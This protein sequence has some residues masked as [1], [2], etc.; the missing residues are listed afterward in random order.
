MNSENSP[1]GIALVFEPEPIVEGRGELPIIINY[2]I[3]SFALQFVSPR[4]G[5]SPYNACS[6]L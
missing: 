4:I 6:Y 1:E 2:E 3:F 5:P